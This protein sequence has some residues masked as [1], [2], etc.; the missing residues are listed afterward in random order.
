MTT[1]TALQAVSERLTTWLFEAALPLWRERGFTG[2]ETGFVETID[3]KGQPTD[4]HH[5]ARVQPRQVYCF[6]EAGHRG[7]TG[8]WRSAAEQ[9]LEGFDRVFARPDGLFGALADAKGTLIDDRF[10]LYNHAFAFLA[11]S[12][13]AD[14]LPHRRDEMAER[15]RM[16]LSHIEAR[17]RHPEAGFHEDNPPR[18]PLG[19]NPHMHLFEAALSSEATEGFDKVT[20][21][22]LTD[23]IADLCLTRFIDAESGAL[24]EFFDADW[25]PFEGEKGR[26]V[27]PGHQFEWAWLLTRYGE[28]RGRA[29]AIAAARRLFD[30]AVGHGVCPQRD[31]A[32]MTLD[33]RFAVIDPIARLWPQTEWLKAAIRFASMAQGE[34]RA[35]YLASAERA[36]AAL[37]RFL[38]TP[39]SGLWFDKMR[40]DGS[41]VDE[42]APASTFYHIVC[43]IFELRDCLE[44]ME[45]DPA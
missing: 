43:C 29:D 10:D 33:D 11:F 23:E 41:F 36:A 37:D 26:V 7:W 24:R 31:V 12:H 42:A 25:A 22:N 27:E 38:A 20:W 13:L 34:E 14:A 1:V 8:D 45:K 40:P 15:S 21:A 28:R 4:A 17:C 16:L 9:G 35:H 18:F 3:M 39:I 5:R 2:P 30:I 19:S 6:A 44:R 32:I